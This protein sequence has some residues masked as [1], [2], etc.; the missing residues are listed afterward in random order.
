MGIHRVLVTG[1]GG[2]IGTALTEALLDRGY[3]VVALDRFFFGPTLSGLSHPNLRIVKD[4]IRWVSSAAFRDV[5][6]VCDLAALPEDPAGALDPDRIAAVNAAG[7][8]RTATLA[9]AS[10]A[11]RYVLA[12]SYTVYDPEGDGLTEESPVAP[13]TAHAQADLEAQEALFQ[14]RNRRFCA[15]VLRLAPV[16][17]LSRRMRFDLVLNAMALALLQKR[18]IPVPRDG[19]QWLPLVHVRDAAA[20]FV[21]AIEIDT[22]EVNGQVFNV[23]SDEQNV[24]HLLLALR[25][26]EALGTPC[27]IAWDDGEPSRSY[28]VSFEKIRRVLGFSPRF[29]PEDGV[30]E[31]ARAFRERLVD[32]GPRTRAAEWCRH[33]VQTGEL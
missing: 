1:A 2:Y 20:A 12:S 3:E 19:L 10:G 7:R 31:I 33:L 29:Q 27:S 9:K 23:G 30:R 28:R 16:Y 25:A 18:V 26:A 17:G 5:D 11:R 21:K 22:A 15:T 8:V 32:T 24:Q 6:A 4:D 13:H 14:L